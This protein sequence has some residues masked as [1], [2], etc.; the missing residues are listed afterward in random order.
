MKFVVVLFLACIGVFIEAAPPFGSTESHSTG[1]FEF[2]LGNLGN[3][4]NIVV[5]RNIFVDKDPKG[6]QKVIFSYSVSSSKIFPRKS[7]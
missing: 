6:Q 2:S 4:G 7:F 3:P 1:Q 5:K